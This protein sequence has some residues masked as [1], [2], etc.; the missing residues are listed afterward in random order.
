MTTATNTAS[1]PSSSSTPS[2]L[3]E[4]LAQFDVGGRSSAGSGVSGRSMLGW[5][6]TFCGLG[7]SG[8]VLF[9][10][11]AAIFHPEKIGLPLRLMK[12]DDLNMTVPSGK[13]QLPPV[14]VTLAAYL[15]TAILIAIVGKIG[16]ALLKLGG[17]LVLGRMSES[18]GQIL[19]GE[20]GA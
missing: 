10:I 3:R 4:Q 16:V 7:V 2:L 12:L 6:L 13:I 5:F 11:H 20:A 14:A 15:V 9:S 8:W 18:P 19:R 17:S 1:R